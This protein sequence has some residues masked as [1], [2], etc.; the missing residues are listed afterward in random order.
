MR[1]DARGLSAKLASE[2]T[3]HARL[4]GFYAIW[5]ADAFPGLATSPLA[6]LADAPQKEKWPAGD[7]SA[8]ALAALP[9]LP[10]SQRPLQAAFGKLPPG[11]YVLEFRGGMSGVPAPQALPFQVPAPAAG[12]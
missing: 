1:V 11:N 6:S 4:Q 2:G 5:R 9:V 12:R 7:V 3:A 8:A 10:G